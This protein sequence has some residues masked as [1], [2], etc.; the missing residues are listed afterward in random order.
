[1]DLLLRGSGGACAPIATPMKFIVN[2][3]REAGIR[4]L[5]LGVFQ[6]RL[7]LLESDGSSRLIALRLLRSGSGQDDAFARPESGFWWSVPTDSQV[8]ALSGSG[9]SIEQQGENLAA[10]LLTYRGGSPVW[11][12]GSARMP[13]NIVRIPLIRMVGGDEPF[14]GPNAAPDAEPGPSLNLQFLGP[15]HA[16]AWLVHP[17]SGLS[18]AIEVQELNLLRLPFE[19]ERNGA[20]WKGQWALVAEDRRQAPLIDLVD[21]VTAD[22]ESFQLRDVG[23]EMTLR[24]RLGEIGGHPVPAFCTLENGAERL[25]DFDHIGL[26]RLSGIDVDGRPVRLVRLPR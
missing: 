4:Q 13:G 19:T 7:Y 6:V 3:A 5:A 17:L 8:P 21:L 16:N 24:C 9:L 2:P 12:F 11:Y 10:T 15:S 25:A 18:P 22:A 1:M 26:D 14:A 23:G 20:G